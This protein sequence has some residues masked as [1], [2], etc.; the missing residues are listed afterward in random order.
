MFGI[1]EDKELLETWEMVDKVLSCAAGKSAQVHDM[2]R[3]GKKQQSGSLSIVGHDLFP[4]SCIVPGIGIFCLL[5]YGSCQIAL[6]TN[7]S[8]F[9][10][11]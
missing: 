2:F 5:G 8:R 11:T 9:I 3:L 7:Q 6:T 4:L 10:L 1:S